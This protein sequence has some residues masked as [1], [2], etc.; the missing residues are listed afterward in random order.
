MNA[1]ERI[2]LSPSS[3]SPDEGAWGLD[4]RRGADSS[5]FNTLRPP[6]KCQHD[7]ASVKITPR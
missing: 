6:K 4:G 5:K 3:S 7:Q 2:Y 1:V